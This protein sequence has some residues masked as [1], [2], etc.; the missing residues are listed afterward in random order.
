MESFKYE[1]TLEKG[2][3]SESRNGWKRKLNLVSWN[4]ATPKF[5]IKEIM[6]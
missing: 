2:I 3:L 5:D 1:V 6:Q 4:G